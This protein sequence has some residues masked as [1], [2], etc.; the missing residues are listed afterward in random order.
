MKKK[1]YSIIGACMLLAL[2]AV[3]THILSI[4][5][6]G[7]NPDYLYNTTNTTMNG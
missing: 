3:G 2:L 1:V 7:D 5:G 6:D 4:C